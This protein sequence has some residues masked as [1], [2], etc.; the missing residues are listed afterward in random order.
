[1]PVICVGNWAT[2]VTCAAFLFVNFLVGRSAGTSQEECSLTMI[3]S[4]DV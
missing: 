1:M 4:I 3:L 2:R